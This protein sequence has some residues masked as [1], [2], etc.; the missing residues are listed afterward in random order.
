MESVKRKNMENID[1]YSV[2]GVNK[3]A[4]EVV[5]RAAY[6][7]LAQKYHPDKWDGDISF[8]N[9]KMIEINEAYAHLEKIMLKKSEVRSKVKINNPED[10]KKFKQNY[11]DTLEG[12]DEWKKIPV[13]G[14]IP[15]YVIP[16]VLCVVGLASIKAF[17]KFLNS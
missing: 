7:A 3:D 6:R 15:F 13:L 11:R 12:N 5:I 2:L 8:A 1:Y 17:L 4:D 16:I 10:S 9:K 14:K